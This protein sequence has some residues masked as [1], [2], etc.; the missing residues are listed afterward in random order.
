MIAFLIAHLI[1]Y[2]DYYNLAAGFGCAGWASW[3]IRKKK[4]D[5]P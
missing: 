2:S 5:A 1:A 3:I 4:D